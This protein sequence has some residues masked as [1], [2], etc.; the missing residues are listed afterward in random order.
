MF[1]LPC[2]GLFFEFATKSQFC[3]F[4]VLHNFGFELVSLIVSFQMHEIISF[5][6][7]TEFPSNF[8]NSTIIAEYIA[9]S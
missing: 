6:I 8:S 9:S 1:E 5:S 7:W 3:I 4:F 2:Y